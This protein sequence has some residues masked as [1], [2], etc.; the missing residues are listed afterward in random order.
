[1]KTKKDTSYHLTSKISIEEDYYTAI[2]TS[3]LRL[4]E[5]KLPDD[6]PITIDAAC[7]KDNDELDDECDNNNDSPVVF[8]LDVVVLICDKPGIAGGK[9]LTNKKT[10]SKIKCIVL[11]VTAK[12]I[13][14]DDGDEQ[15]MISPRKGEAIGSF[16][17]DRD[18][19][20]GTVKYG[21][22]RQQMLKLYSDADKGD[23]IGE[24]SS[25]FIKY[26]NR[27]NVM[28][29]VTSSQALFRQYQEILDKQTSKAVDNTFTIKLSLG[30]KKN[31]DPAL[32]YDPAKTQLHHNESQQ[33]TYQSP[34]K[35]AFKSRAA[36]RNSSRVLSEDNSEILDLFEQVKELEKF[37]NKMAQQ[38]KVVFLLHLGNHA[39]EKERIESDLLAGHTPKLLFMKQY[40][41]MLRLIMP[42]DRDFGPTAE[43]GVLPDINEVGNAKD[44]DDPFKKLASSIGSLVESKKTAAAPP[45]ANA[46]C[47]IKYGDGIK[48]S[49]TPGDVVHEVSIL[50]S[51]VDEDNGHAMLLAALQ[52]AQQDGSLIFSCNG[53][54]N[55]SFNRYKFR[56][57]NP[58][59]DQLKAMTLEFILTGTKDTLE[60][61]ITCHEKKDI[62]QQNVLI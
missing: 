48:D 24:H 12:V 55:K 38:H 58:S 3:N 17:V 28:N 49:F 26:D 29:R 10:H 32:D 43:G 54:T 15:Y 27:S 11:N 34:A 37:K 52:Q 62:V 40:A 5:S 4:D 35:E 39:D 41:K 22:I 46:I 50:A 45:K 51:A 31:N 19:F 9:A 8:H 53:K 16:L 59:S 57:Q 30:K 13:D 1:M 60:I 47:F 61:I 56:G 18:K 2:S 21:S 14:K 44:E 42:G 7:E 23:L 36:R 33:M 25:I 20:C 6:S